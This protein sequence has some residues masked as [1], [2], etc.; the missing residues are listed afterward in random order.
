MPCAVEVFSRGRIQISRIQATRPTQDG[1]AETAARIDRSFLHAKGG[2]RRAVNFAAPKWMLVTRREV[3]QKSDILCPHFD[4]E[5]ALETKPTCYR[6]PVIVKCKE[7]LVLRYSMLLFLIVFSTAAPL[8]ADN[9]DVELLRQMPKAWRYFQA[10]NHKNIGVL[11]FR[12]RR[13]GGAK[14]AFSDTLLSTQMAERIENALILTMDTSQSGFNVIDN[15]SETA[16]EKLRNATYATSS[17]REALFDIAYNLP[18]RNQRAVKA[19]VFLTGRID[20]SDD[21]KTTR[22]TLEIFT[23][24]NPAEFRRV[25]SFVVNTDRPMLT[26]FGQNYSVS[27]HG[28][29]LI[30]G[31][32]NSIEEDDIIDTVRDGSFD[33]DTLVDEDDLWDEDQLIDQDDE[34]EDQL[35]KQQDERVSDDESASTS[36]VATKKEINEQTTLASITQST[37]R[38]TP[39]SVLDYPVKFRVLYDDQLQEINTRED[40]YYMADPEKGQ[41]VSFQVEN[42]T[43][44]K[45]G[46]V[47]TVNGV[48]TLYEEQGPVTDLTKWVLL[49]NQNQA[50]VIKGFY[51]ND[52]QTYIPI[53]GKGDEETD[54]LWEDLGGDKYA[55]KITV[56]IFRASTATGLTLRTSGGSLKD[57]VSSDQNEYDDADSYEEKRKDLERGMNRQSA[58]RGLMGHGSET[59]KERLESD[60]ISR[61]ALTDSFTIVYYKRDRDE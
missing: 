51:Q 4:R 34:N 60:H 9:L 6:K 56:T 24:E 1:M 46:M 25:H 3:K 45:L 42:M 21:W 61:V 8:K 54:E 36:D 44:E 11:N 2:G 16:S 39:S 7:S 35:T 57:I 10:Y 49:P 37:R 31:T 52:N 58:S 32:S 59:K 23:R 38:Q 22:V 20:L 48:S 47:L 5:S 29:K 41:R 55:G 17:G 33:F 53:V 40:G 43:D 50:Y 27:L 14:P 13:P 28:S 12:V 15:A 30:R 26:D 19:D 18:L